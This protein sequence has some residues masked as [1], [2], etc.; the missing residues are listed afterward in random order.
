MDL[1]ISWLKKQSP[2]CP[3]LFLRLVMT[4]MLT[5]ASNRLIQFR[6]H[7]PDARFFS[8]S[9]RSRNQ[10]DFDPTASTGGKGEGEL[11]LE[12]GERE[13]KVHLRWKLRALQRS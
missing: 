9:H 3:L 1:L 7:F 5:G 4:T 12:T 11:K 10:G 2:A 13:S 6:N 8:I